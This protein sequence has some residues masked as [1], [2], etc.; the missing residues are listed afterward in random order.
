MVDREDLEAA[1]L[2]EVCTC[3]YYDLADSLETESDKVLLTIVNRINTCDV[4][5]Q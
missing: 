3:L 1:A 5:G 4:C 2:R